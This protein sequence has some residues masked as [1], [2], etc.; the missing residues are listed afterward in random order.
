MSTAVCPTASSLLV[1]C[2]HPKVACSLQACRL[3]CMQLGTV[4][5]L[6]SASQQLLSVFVYTATCLLA[7]CR[8]DQLVL[9]AAPEFSGLLAACRNGHNELEDPSVTL[10]LTYQAVANHPPV[11][12]LYSSHL[13]QQGVLTEADVKGWQVIA[14]NP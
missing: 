13:L 8:P 7:A 3:T 6:S 9:P 4:P 1:A 11:A 12:Q 10:P 2:M 14:L 5:D